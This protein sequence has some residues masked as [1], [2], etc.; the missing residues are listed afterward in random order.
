MRTNN[1]LI[2]DKN[3]FKGAIFDA[4]GAPTPILT[5]YQNISPFNPSTR[6]Y[7]W[8]IGHSN[9]NGT[10]LCT[11]VLEHSLAIDKGISCGIGWEK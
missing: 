6:P 8:Y 11:H 2:I 9:L 10:F 7:F 4:K 1:N 5:K 3:I